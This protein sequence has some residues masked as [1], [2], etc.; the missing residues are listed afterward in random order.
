MLKRASASSFSALPASS[1]LKAWRAIRDRPDQALDIANG[2]RPMNGSGSVASS[3]TADNN[4]KRRCEASRL[5]RKCPH[6][7][8]LLREPRNA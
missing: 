6:N 2:L 7:T 5:G 3:R 4:G 1:S 8:S